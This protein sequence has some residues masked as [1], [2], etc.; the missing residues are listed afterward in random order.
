MD[1]NR[2]ANSCLFSRLLELKV[3]QKTSDSFE[4]AQVQYE[5]IL[6]FLD[7]SAHS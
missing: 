2:T 4:C 1:L 5:V 7:I 6:F 3:M